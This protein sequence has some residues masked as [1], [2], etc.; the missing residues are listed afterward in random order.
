MNKHLTNY[1]LKGHQ[2]ISLPGAPQ[3]LGP[4]LKTAEVIFSREVK[5]QKIRK[6]ERNE[7]VKRNGITK[8]ESIKEADRRNSKAKEKTKR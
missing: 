3:S 1:G 5:S 8:R 4:A 2:I 6:A 7:E